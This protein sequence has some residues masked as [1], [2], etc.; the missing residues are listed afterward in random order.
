MTAIK[1]AISLGGVGFSLIHTDEG[2]VLD[3]YDTYEEAEAEIEE[4]AADGF[5][6]SDWYVE[7]VQRESDGDW[8]CNSGINR[9][10]QA[11]DQ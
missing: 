4:V 8:Y 1:Y 2:N 5:D 9:S 11:R 10:Q 3:L 7:E 6:S